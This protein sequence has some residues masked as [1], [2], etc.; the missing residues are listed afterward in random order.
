MSFKDAKKNLITANSAQIASLTADLAVAA[1]SDDNYSIID[2]YDYFPQYSDNKY[3]TVDNNKNITMDA[4]QI[5]IT[6]ES[7]SQ[8][9]PFQIPRYYDG[10]DLSK[11]T[12]CIRYADRLN[13]DIV[14]EYPVINAMCND[15]YIRFGWLI[16]DKLTQNAGDYIFEIRATGKVPVSNDKN[17]EYAWSTRP[18][19]KIN[20]LQGIDINGAVE[21]SDSGWMTAFEKRIINYTEDAKNAAKQAAASASSVDVDNIAN[22]VI[23][24]VTDNFNKTSSLENYYTKS[25]INDQK[26]GIAEQ[27]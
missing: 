2:G 26:S 7:N 20:V 1:E 14:G 8:Y 12:I 15:T 19:G 16:D 4:T 5:N 21:P 23:N 11:M 10:I 3:S 27:I 17:I 13:G 25:E 18:N 22:S 24:K 9:I 6:Q